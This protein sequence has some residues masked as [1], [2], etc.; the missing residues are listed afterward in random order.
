M[1]VTTSATV[2]GV[3]R[4][5]YDGD[6]TRV[7]QVNA[8]GTTVTTCTCDA[9]HRLTR[10]GVFTYTYSA[11]G[12]LVR[13]Q[14][15]TATLVYTYTADGLRVAQSS[16]GAV[17]T[18]AWDWATPVPELL[19]AGATRYLL[20]AET[21]GQWDGVTWTYVLPDALGSVR[22]TVD[23]AGAVTADREW[24]PY[25]AEVGGAQA[26]LGYT[27]EWQDADV[28][29]VYLRARWYQPTLSQFI[30]PD[31]VT[32]DFRNPPSINRYLYSFGNPLHF[33]DPSGQIPYDRNRAVQYALD[34]KSPPPNSEYGEFGNSDC[35]N[36]V[37]QALRAGYFPED[38]RWFFEKP[39]LVRASR[40]TGY[41]YAS[42]PFKP[43]SGWLGCTVIDPRVGENIDQ[44]YCGEAWALTDNLFDYLTRDRG[45]AVSYYYGEQVATGKDADKQS[46]DTGS[47]VLPW[48][49]DWDANGNA[50]TEYMPVS[51]DTRLGDVV[52][53]RQEHA[54]AVRAG[55]QY[56]HVAFIVGWGALTRRGG[57]PPDNSN[58]PIWGDQGLTPHI[59]DHSSP[60]S[61]W[62]SRAINDTFTEVNMMA[63]VHIPDDIP[64][65]KRCR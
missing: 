35:T 1:Y 53:Y 36:F 26:G 63:I 18:F 32:P 27:G 54:P 10:D 9:A 6:G 48:A 45:F 28:G 17:T 23:R 58:E 64:V 33:T 40:C 5:F 8:S 46:V 62:G 42:S 30:S 4:F 65:T 47:P 31:P 51:F 37:S 41:H 3:T 25:G 19:S 12:Q 39:A 21:L 59:V 13:A 43:C 22:Q 2:G 29:L 44:A 20:G 24:S 11:A 52:F 61:G 38:T 34:W 16:N 49:V 57:L 55:G 7:Q 15:V 50:R 60:A 14:S 56:N